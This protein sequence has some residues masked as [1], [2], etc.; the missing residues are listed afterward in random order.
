MNVWRNKP[1]T[2]T[3][4][5]LTPEIK[6]VQV[7]FI[8]RAK[9]WKGRKMWLKLYVH[10]GFHRILKTFRIV[11]ASPI[12]HLRSCD[13]HERKTISWFSL[14]FFCPSPF[15]FQ[16]FLF[17]FPIPFPSFPLSSPFFF[18]KRKTESREQK[19]FYSFCYTTQGPLAPICL[20][21]R[22]LLTCIHFKMMRQLQDHFCVGG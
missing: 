8:P 11:W 12:N 10:T 16:F 7:Q 15:S 3:S 13:H 20:P 4:P 18:W 21:G 19:G 14:W 17:S 6:P 2:R 5:P 22:R 9:T 1:E